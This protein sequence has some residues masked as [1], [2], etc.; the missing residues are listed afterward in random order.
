MEESVQETP[1]IFSFL[2]EKN[3]VGLFERLYRTADHSQ[4]NAQVGVHA[5]MRIDTKGQ[6]RNLSL[7]PLCQ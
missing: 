6:K 7:A 4:G 1:P 3:R 5:E 2:L